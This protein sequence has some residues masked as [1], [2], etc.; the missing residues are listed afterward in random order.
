MHILILNSLAK[1]QSLSAVI[2]KHSVNLITGIYIELS[3]LRKENR[4]ICRLD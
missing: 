2:Q 1:L 3:T 4:F